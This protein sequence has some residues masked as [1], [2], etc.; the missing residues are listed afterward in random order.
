MVVG[1]DY[2]LRSVMGKR[3]DPERVHLQERLLPVAGNRLGPADGLEVGVFFCLQTPAPDAAG[4]PATLAE[5][6]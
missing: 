6:T 5:E 3:P 1:E 2:L 4:G